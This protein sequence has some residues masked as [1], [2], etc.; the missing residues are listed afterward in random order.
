MNKSQLFL[1]VAMLALVATTCVT[2]ATLRDVWPRRGG[3]LGH[4]SLTITGN[5]FARNGV[6][7]STRVFVGNQ[8]CRVEPYYSSDTQLVCYSPEY[9]GG[10]TYQEVKVQIDSV[11]KTE[12]AS[13]GGHCFYEYT[14][15]QTPRVTSITGA[16]AYGEDVVRIDGSFK[17][18]EINH[19][20]ALVGDLRCDFELT[21]VGANEQDTI[22]NSAYCD[23]PENEAGR[24]NVTFTIGT[25]NTYEG[26][27]RASNE[28]TAYT[29]TLEGEVYMV[30]QFPRIEELSQQTS[31]SNGGAILT[32]KGTHFAAD[33]ENVEVRV[34]GAACEVISTSV[35]EITCRPAAASTATSTANFNG[36]YPSYRGA[37]QE[38]Y[39]D[40]E[41]A[42]HGSSFERN[43]DKYPNNPDE[44]NVQTHS[45]IGFEWPDENRDRYMARVSGFFRAP[46]TADYRFYVRGDDFVDFKMALSSDAH[47]LTTINSVQY[48]TANYFIYPEQISELVSLT[49]G[50]AYYYEARYS[51]GGGGD[52]LRVA[53][54]IE[55][56]ISD[57]T[58][59][60][61]GLGEV[62]KFHMA[63]DRVREQQTFEVNNVGGGGFRLQH[64]DKISDTIPWNATSSEFKNAIRSVH[65]CSWNTAVMSRVATETAG[66]ETEASTVTGYTWVVEFR[67]PS[68]GERQLVNILNVNLEEIAGGQNPSISSTVTQA[69]SVPL[70]GR[71]SLSFNHNTTSFDVGSF[72]YKTGAAALEAFDDIEDVNIYTSGNAYEDFTILIEFLRPR[73]DVPS[74]VFNGDDLTGDNVNI[75]VSTFR[76]GANEP[77]FDPIPARWLE[78]AS[79]K[80]SV[81]VWVNDIKATCN[82][83]TGVSRDACSFEFDDDITP[84]VASVSAS[85][86]S[87]GSELV[88][89]G[90][91][92]STNAADVSVS[93]VLAANTDVRVPCVISAI[94]AT[95]ITCNVAAAG[96][97]D[98]NVEVVSSPAGVASNSDAFVVSY[99]LSSSV[100]FSPTSGSAAGGTLV[101]VSGDGF[102]PFPN[103]ASEAATVV[104]IGGVACVVESSTATSLVCRSPSLVDV[105]LANVSAGTTTEL[106]KDVSIGGGAALSTQF[107]Y[108]TASTPAVTSISPAEFSAG[109][110]TTVTVTG[111]GL[112]SDEDNLTVTLDGSACTVV[113]GSLTDGTT[114]E[115]VVVRGNPSE[116][117][118]AVAPVVYIN[119]LG[120]ASTDSV[121]VR[122]EL[123]VDS[124]SSSSGSREGG[125]TLVISGGGFHSEADSNIV[126]VTYD[127]F[128]VKRECEI[129]GDASSTSSL[130]CT[131]PRADDAIDFDTVTTTIVVKVNG[132]EA[133]CD[134]SDCAY[135]YLASSTAQV[136]SVE[137]S[138]ASQGETIVITFANA[139]VAELESASVG[140]ADCTVTA[141]TATTVSCTVPSVTAGPTEVSLQF[142]T[143][144]S[145]S[146]AFDV[147]LTVTSVTTTHSD[148]STIS[149][150]GGKEFTISGSGFSMHHSH[151]TLLNAGNPNNTVPCNVTAASKTEIT[152]VTSQANGDSTGPADP[153]VFRVE[154][155]SH[156]H[157]DEELGSADFDASAFSMAVPSGEIVAVSYTEPAVAG[158]SITLVVA[159][160]NDLVS[161]SIGG[162]DCPVTEITDS[163]ISCSLG[164]SPAGS[165]LVRVLT[166]EGLVYTSRSVFV[167]LTYTGLSGDTDGSF[168][169][170]NAI[171]LTGA[172]F[173]DTDNTKVTICDIPCDVTA[174]S[175][176]S[177]TCSPGEALSV[178]L[179]DSH[180]HREASIL[181]GT[182]MR[183]NSARV[184]D[185]DLDSYEQW[186]SGSCYF[187]IEFGALRAQIT[188]IRYFPLFRRTSYVQNSVFEV[189]A[190]GETWETIHTVTGQVHEGFNYFDVDPSTISTDVKYVRYNPEG[191]YCGINE[192]EVIGHLVLHENENGA[193]DVDVT[194]TTPSDTYSFSAPESV[195]ASVSSEGNAALEYSYSEAN[196]PAVTDVSPDWGTARGGTEVVV[197][198]SGF[199]VDSPSSHTVEFNGIS[200]EVTASTATTLT[201]TT[202]ARTTI[203]TKSLVVTVEGKG[204]ALVPRTVRFR[205]LD[206][207]SEVST[208]K[209]NEPPVEGD[210]VVVPDGQ[211][212][213]LDV[214]PPKLSVLLIHG[215]LIFDRKDLNLD[216][217]Y[218]FVQGGVME[219]GTEDEPF[220]Q[221]AVITLHGDRYEDIELPTIGV[222]VLAV[223][224]TKFTSHDHGHGHMVAESD[225]GYLDVHGAPRL[226]TWT[227]VAETAEAGSTTIVTAEDVDF[228]AGEILVLTSSSTSM[229]ETEEVE[230][231][232]LGDDKRTITLTAP[233]RHTHVSYWY[234]VAG[235]TVDLRVEVGL[236][237]RNVVIQGSEES[238]PQ[239]FGVHTVAVHGGTYRIENVEVRRCG[240]AFNLGRYCTHSHMADVM[241]H[242]YVKSNSIHHS[243]QR[244]VTVHGSHHMTV[245]HNVAYHVMGHNYFIE[246]GNER[247]NVI[248]GNL[249]V[250]TL[251][252]SALLKSDTKPATFWT[253][254]P[255]NFWRHNVAAGCTNDGFWLELPG[256]PGGPSFTTSICPVHGPLGQFFNNTAHSNGVHGLRV[257]PVYLPLADPC[258]SN[259]G[260]SPQ[261]FHDFTAWHN[262]QHGIF[263]KLNGDLH[264]VNAKLVENSGDEIF[265]TKLEEVEY[266]NDPHIVNLLAVGSIDPERAVNKRAIFAPQNEFFYVGSA[267][268]VN[269]GDAG[270]LA[271]C[272]KCD[273][274]EDTK[275]GAYT[276]RFEGLRF[277]NT[278]RRIKWTG[279]KKQIFHDLDGTLTGIEAGT[280]TPYYSFNDWEECEQRG[281]ELDDGLL[282]DASVRVRRLEIDGVEPN[283]MDWK[284]I[285]MSTPHGTDNFRFHPKEFYG[286]AVPVVAKKQVE[287]TWDTLIDW[288]E[289]NTRWSL[290]EYVEE[291]DNGEYA[292]LTFNYTDYRFGFFTTHEEQRVA[293]LE[294]MVQPTDP[295]GSSYHDQDNKKWHLALTTV[296]VSAG[297]QMGVETEA[298]QC[299]LEG[300][301]K[302][303]RPSFSKPV[304]WSDCTW[305]VS[306]GCPLAG[307]DVTIPADKYVIA[308]V[309]LPTMKQLT[310]N[311]K[312]AF[313]SDVD[314][315]LRAEKILVNGEWT[316]G[317]ASKPATADIRISL[318]GTRS[319]PV[320]LVDNSLFLGNKVLAILGKVEWYGNPR[321]TSWTRLASTAEAGATTITLNEDVDWA[322]GDEIVFTPT[323]YDIDELETATI[324]SVDGRTVTL[325]DA[326]S[327]RHFADDVTVD[328]EG[329]EVSL[330]GAVG[331]L[332]RNII[333]EG[334]QGSDPDS[335][336]YG[337]HIVVASLPDRDGSVGYD[338]VGSVNFNWVQFRY[339]GQQEMEHAAVYFEYFPDAQEDR[340]PR[341]YITNSAFSHT[342]NYAVVGRKTDRLS[343]TRNVVHRAFR[344]A[345][346]LYD[347]CVSSVIN[348]NLIAGSLLSPDETDEWVTP[349]AGIFLESLPS[350]MTG[351]VVS[352]SFDAGFTFVPHQCGSTAVIHD[353]EA[354]GVRIG[355]F[356]LS[357]VADCV[358]VSRFTAWKC[359]H[360][361]ILT[362][363]QRANLE[364][365]DSVVSDSHIGLSFDFF[366]HNANNHASVINSV[367]MGSTAAT[368]C[369]E[370]LDCY[371]ATEDDPQGVTCGSV[372]GT[373][374][375][376][377]GIL[378]PQYTNRGKTCE[379]DGTLDVC[380]PPNRPER[381]CGMPWE[382]KYGLPVS[383]FGH[384]YVTKTRFAYFA[385]TEC[386]DYRSVAIAHNP[387]QDD[388]TPPITVS[389]LS[390]Y[391]SSRDARVWVGYTEGLT[392]SKCATYCDGLHAIVITDVDGTLM[393]SSDAAGGSVIASV[394]TLARNAPDCV[395]N[396]AW[397]G[398]ECPN[399]P[400]RAVTFENVDSDRGSRKLGPVDLIRLADNRTYGAQG[401]VDDHCAKRFFFGQYPLVAEPGSHYRVQPTASIP[402]KTR[403]SWHSLDKKDSV[404]LSIFY[405]QPMALKVTVGGKRVNKAL[406]YPTLASPHGSYLFNP[407]ERMLHL[408]L[409]GGLDRQ[410][411]VETLPVVQITIHMETTLDNFY[412]ESVIQNIATLLQID[413][414]RIKIVDV[415][416]GSVIT[417]I[418]ISDELVTVIPEDEA[419]ARQ[420]VDRMANVTATLVTAARSGTLKK[421][422]PYPLIDVTVVPLSIDDEGEAVTVSYAEEDPWYQTDEAFIGLAVA[423]FVIVGA[424]FAVV[425]MK[426]KKGRSRRLSA[427]VDLAELRHRHN[428]DDDFSIP[429]I[430]QHVPNTLK[431]Q[432]QPAKT[433]D[434]R[435]YIS[436]EGASPSPA[437]PSSTGGER[438]TVV[439][440]A[441]ANPS[442]LTVV[443]HSHNAK[444]ATPSG[445]RSG[446][447]ATSMSHTGE[448]SHSTPSSHMDDEE[449][450]KMN[451][452]PKKNPLVPS[453]STEEM[454]KAHSISSKELG[455]KDDMLHVENQVWATKLKKAPTP[456]NKTVADFDDPLN[457]PE[458]VFGTSGK[459]VCAQTYEHPGADE[460]PITMHDIVVVL[461]LEKEEDGSNGNRFL[462]EKN[463]KKGFVPATHL[464]QIPPTIPKISEYNRKKIGVLSPRESEAEL[465]KP[466]A[467]TSNAAPSQDNQEDQA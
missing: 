378:T 276:F 172:G 141:S 260:P 36:T 180:E 213:L 267:T 236:L 196:T 156:E 447:V 432:K 327:F 10:S 126:W 59:Q 365:S 323:S 66:T 48:W 136:T 363:D 116:T 189:S 67:C 29:S 14:N 273:S 109:V 214:S 20:T 443:T 162:V 261:Y 386:G 334:D 218:I 398:Y 187:G 231:A 79:E 367:V 329:D 73:G 394:P 76:E 242:S 317:T 426:K 283:E 153:L 88:L 409:R 127:D 72:N 28:H 331:L 69:A 341:S 362:V 314:Q 195:S 315:H 210:F 405:T 55:T 399:M 246:D 94:T 18:R 114:F 184:F 306:G 62:Q 263:G 63:S 27:G 376:R 211:A 52:Y 123:R 389:G 197:T 85:S 272:A 446:S 198:G 101:T 112:G 168:A 39:G 457:I 387:S 385:H 34:A 3:Y 110:S 203:N 222:K 461:G 77:F 24:Y 292:L 120:Y 440:Q 312:L 70:G 243:F 311:G 336:R 78:V 258:D 167:A 165:H 360:V 92:F 456:T 138:S 232:S 137:P 413:E 420:M 427:P 354:H 253:S 115:C 60:Y 183:S 148:S 224:D 437:A 454:N 377:V 23:L 284:H 227:K 318:S 182:P 339:C 83:A 35:D 221:R 68:V 240:Q 392:A 82:T 282:C 131:V 361:G 300:C 121:T 373:T 217:T 146:V 17:A 108:T 445:S 199:I 268:I 328:D 296:G 342:Y 30:E 285:V 7:G 404:L 384:L 433:N 247:K 61:I 161:I 319:S 31:G 332:N 46:I 321:G 2:A 134:G 424:A 326:L 431:Q 74:I 305:T 216:A 75:T 288:R 330:R 348:H 176:N 369:D 244:A 441:A 163:S 143:G 357:T 158:S 133:P 395:P 269:Y 375:S 423:G 16:D 347:T 128:E 188:R 270:A 129:D 201:C 22:Y 364:V 12:F 418:E 255:D 343:L 40:V 54:H 174:S 448:D 142:S 278:E 452:Q 41:S 325:Q 252:S 38:Y 279:W 160:I 435:V 90:T 49:A 428:D 410:V 104:T 358:A 259:S 262:G 190:D 388:F 464:A 280:V 453:F 164:N 65:P 93:L 226:R 396:T 15:S 421:V 171:T 289:M 100:S 193:C 370:R 249:G 264:H 181:K 132:I 105:E 212:V 122:R 8:E 460:L 19:F 205:Y 383:Q 106:A 335:N 429:P 219:V 86:V 438:N 178:S 308:D 251:R 135:S 56:P 463:G 402:P 209:N 439:K 254:S 436:P 44:V 359:S 159:G 80:P 275:Q 381:L 47:N 406:T 302:P 96:A 345:I 333:F 13:C 451:E 353:N 99:A 322:A 238:T 223:S 371:A 87:A 239:L 391:E 310:I 154:A 58:T 185:G 412:G 245:A 467:R 230:V 286:W 220:L 442:H 355:A 356:V 147:S 324:A 287:V 316:I 202:G 53:V 297:V 149:V 151:V 229:Y 449:D 298:L 304:M 139:D 349:Q 25:Q 256:H 372:L 107:V 466:A 175:Y 117:Q 21:D 368:E 340:T 98:Y 170:G 235:E 207:W 124:I 266:N 444:S 414:S 274:S 257:Y 9:K 84:T 462:I 119:G 103:D 111:T 125:N 50:E 407:Q 382:K 338:F 173:S 299:P 152:C 352:A 33:K 450:A 233:L 177:I 390:W 417:D 281:S 237:T 37:F 204:G 422:I 215:E 91:G 350:S 191:G 234:E 415:R 277:V 4:T 1:S 186:W 374:Y 411:R 144:S 303:E 166:K 179:L 291:W 459:Y 366:R 26:Y 430:P 95:V 140:D 89:T 130:S 465:I 401:P 71:F 228:A 200:C 309:P 81:E 32:I 208:W 380:R 225:R 403:W 455:I 241:S 419:T 320:L 416:V 379:V 206:R 265:W 344:S 155:L 157:H 408:T 295:I 43:D 294:R 458:L 293:G 150:F 301:P 393:G 400:L 6:E 194:V 307:S 337:A 45:L 42:G 118:V 290:P 51:E 248:E 425:M 346:Y 397:G 57:E 434:T 5:G 271:G 250:F 351:N 113:A 169:G 145:T 313:P 192:I 11:D 97:G 64:D 102:V